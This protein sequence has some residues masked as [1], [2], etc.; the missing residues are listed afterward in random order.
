M[1]AFSG[2]WLARQPRPMSSAGAGD[3]GYFP[4]QAFF[5]ASPFCW[6]GSG[7]SFR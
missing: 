1:A 7:L 2:E 4:G 5:V 3:Y 6:S